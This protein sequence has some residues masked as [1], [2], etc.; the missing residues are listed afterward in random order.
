MLLLPAA[1]SLAAF[2]WLLSLHPTATGRTY[3]A[4][5]GVYV[6]A[7]VAWLWIVDQQQPDKWDIILGACVT[8]LGMAIVFFGPRQA[9]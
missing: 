8:M 9:S 5:G 3:A 2:A 4:Y 7:A 6:A 1:V